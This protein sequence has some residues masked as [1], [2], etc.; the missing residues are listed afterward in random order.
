MAY[1]GNQTIY[2]SGV[3]YGN[4][5]GTAAPLTAVCNPLATYADGSQEAATTAGFAR[6]DVAWGTP[7]GA[8]TVYRVRRS[9]YGYPKSPISG[10][11][12][13]SATPGTSTITSDTHYVRPGQTYFYRVFVQRTSGWEVA[14]QT[15]VEAT[16]AGN[17]AA[18]LKNAL[19]RMY[20]SDYYDSAGNYVPADSLAP[21][22]DE[23]PLSQF[24]DG[25]GFWVDTF[26]TQARQFIDSPSKSSPDLLAPRLMSYG[27]NYIQEIPYENQRRLLND[28]W[29]LMTAKGTRRAI[30]AFASDITGWK[31]KA[32]DP[33][34]LVPTMQ[35][36]S[37]DYS[38]LVLDYPGGVVVP[39]EIKLIDRSG[40]VQRGTQVGTYLSGTSTTNSISTITVSGTTVTVTTGGVHGLSTGNLVTI[41]GSSTAANNGRFTVASAPTSTTFTITNGGSV[42]LV[43][44]GA[45]GF[46]FPYGTS[47]FLQSNNFDG[48][49]VAHVFVS[50]DSHA[51]YNLT[52]E[53][54]IDGTTW[55]A[56]DTTLHPT[57]TYYSNGVSGVLTTN[58]SYHYICNVFGGMTSVR[59]TTT[60]RTS[61]FIMVYIT[62]IN[63][64][65]TCVISSPNITVPVRSASTFTAR[66]VSGGTATITA[67]NNF[68]V[69]DTIVQSGFTGADATTT[70][71]MPAGGLNGSFTITAATSTSYSFALSGT[72][73]SGAPIGTPAASCNNPAT[74]SSA[75][76]RP[77]WVYEDSDYPN[78][79]TSASSSV[80]VLQ[81]RFST[82]VRQP[83]FGTNYPP[84][85]A[86]ALTGIPLNTKNYRNYER[87]LIPVE[88]FEAYNFMFAARYVATAIG[89]PVLASTGIY[90]NAYWYDAAKNLLSSESLGT[91]GI[92]AALDWDYFQYGAVAPLGATH[93]GWSIGL[94]ADI[95]ATVHIGGIHIEK[96]V[97]QFINLARIDGA[98]IASGTAQ[99]FWTNQN[100]QATGWPKIIDPVRTNLVTNPSFE[101]N[102][103]GWSTSGSATGQSATAIT[104]TAAGL[105]SSPNLYGGSYLLAVNSG[106]GASSIVSTTV[107]TTVGVT[108]Y[109][110]ARV[111]STTGNPIIRP[112][113]V[114]S[115]FFGTP[116]TPSS[117]WTTV[118]GSFT[119][120]STTHSVGLGTGTT[121]GQT[122]VIDQVC[123]EAATVLTQYFDGLTPGATWT[124][125]ANASTSTITLGSI[126]IQMKSNT[127]GTSEIVSAKVPVQAGS[128]FAYTTPTSYTD[129]TQVTTNYCLS[130]YFT[131]SVARSMSVYALCSDITGTVTTITLVDTVNI[132]V[133]GV[134]H[135]GTFWS[136][137]FGPPNQIQVNGT[138]ATARA[139][140]TAYM[141]GAIVRPSTINNCVY[142]ALNAGT[143]GSTTPT[144]LT[145]I[146]STVTDGTVVWKCVGVASAYVSAPTAYLQLIFSEAGTLANETCLVRQVGIVK[147]DVLFTSG[148]YP[149][150]G[151]GY[152]LTRRSANST[153]SSAG[154]VSSAQLGTQTG[155]YKSE[156]FPNPYRDPRTINVVLEPN[157]INL[158]YLEDS[159]W[160]SLSPSVTY[161]TVVAGMAYSGTT[162]NNLSSTAAGSQASPWESLNIFGQ[163]YIQAGQWFTFS[164]YAKLQNANSG[165]TARLGLG[166]EKKNAYPD[167]VT[168]SSWT[169]VSNTDWVRLSL[170]TQVPYGVYRGRA[171]VQAAGLPANNTDFFFDAAQVELGRVPTDYFN[172]TTSTQDTVSVASFDGSSITKYNAQYFDKKILA[173]GLAAHLADN[174]PATTPYRVVTA[175]DPDWLSLRVR[176]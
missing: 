140:S 172:Y 121:A 37:F 104:Y 4:S 107:N 54:S 141:K 69:G 170:T 110:Q 109:F 130:A 127:A 101:T 35:D 114:G 39:D 56:L 43:A 17:T 46:A 86:G 12:I 149:Y 7:L 167:S 169:P 126:G 105:G 67:S 136:K 74:A 112:Y 82:A 154:T 85:Y 117:S 159:S 2:G 145:S 89:T 8:F 15:F 139:A 41:S 134:G 55:T 77:T 94:D 19:P 92:S 123:V 163:R 32:T 124:G 9:L 138:S 72:V 176:P 173:Y 38:N 52:F 133:N 83:Q 45:S 11:L 103:T 137:M 122:Y 168:Y 102:A 70:G 142:Q 106:T 125:T 33:V 108:Y 5:L 132:D 150:S 36:V 10:D 160:T 115:G 73:A 50:G 53:G 96:I 143:T 40:A 71:G 3:T 88:E 48:Y 23:H 29:F 49:S 151:G 131:G 64:G 75:T 128:N 20:L 120:T 135:Y 175:D 21:P 87:N 147:S 58:A 81:Q 100:N 166:F 44:Q 165:V 113:L 157:R 95:G 57:G 18:A 164:V 26:K 90:M 6:I 28:N 51:G 91:F 119:A 116:Y 171:Y 99:S 25:V 31:C 22:S 66:A 158:M 30:S 59:V 98:D 97:G 161:S 61:G 156:F 79:T 63:V 118:G 146:G 80:R 84:M 153:A 174:V 111:W 68:V 47:Y 34:N 129:P 16:A 42:R 78:K 14:D 162:S 93:M 152:V 65:S 76:T 27:Y 155:S 1:Y 62:P 60:A 148:G 144:Y 13:Y 24:L